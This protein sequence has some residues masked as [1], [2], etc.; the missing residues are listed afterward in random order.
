MDESLA[1][2]DWAQLKAEMRMTLIAIAR[3]RGTISYSE[4]ARGL[5]TATLHHRSPIFT[6]LLIEVCDE[7]ERAG[8]GSLCALVVRKSDGIPGKG[9][10]KAAALQGADVH[11]AE[12]YWRR[13]VEA[14]WAQWAPRDSSTSG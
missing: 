5:Q 13:E 4:L 14:V 6:P 9:Y 10:F 11:D 8:D 1:R 7:A 12:T 3:A 2:A